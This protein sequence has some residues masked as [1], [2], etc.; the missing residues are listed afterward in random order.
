MGENHLAVRSLISGFK[1][2]SLV[3]VWADLLI[4]GSLSHSRH[5]IQPEPCF[6]YLEAEGT[7]DDA[8][9]GHPRVL[10]LAVDLELGRAF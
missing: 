4:Y 5:P 1:I 2:I 7:T 8:H 9:F 6:S 3:I 10:Q